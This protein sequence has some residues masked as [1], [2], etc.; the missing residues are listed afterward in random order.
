MLAWETKL[1]KI[2]KNTERKADTVKT[3]ININEIGNHSH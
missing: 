2:K 3:K 1:H